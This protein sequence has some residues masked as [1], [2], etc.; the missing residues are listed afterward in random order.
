MGFTGAQREGLIDDLGVEVDG[1]GNVG[2]DSEFMATVPGVFVAG[3]IG[4]G[5][6]LIVWAIAEGPRRRGG[7]RHLADRRL[8]AAAPGG[9]HHR[10][11]AVRRSSAGD[12]VPATTNCVVGTGSLR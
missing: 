10:R 6:S 5:Q 7:G 3:D 11:P 1:R 2:R 4:R 12:S 8:D 9:A